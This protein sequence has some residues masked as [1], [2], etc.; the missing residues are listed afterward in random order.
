MDLWRVSYPIVSQVR[1]LRRPAG[2]RLLDN[3][4]YL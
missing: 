3:L 2:L 4:W 1:P